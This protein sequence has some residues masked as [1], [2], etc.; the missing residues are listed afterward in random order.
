M[1]KEQR[2]FHR[3][4]PTKGKEYYAK[5][6][7]RYRRKQRVANN[8][9]RSAEGTFTVEQSIWQYN[10]QHRRCFW[11]SNPVLFADMHLDHIIPVTRFGTNWISNIVCSCAHCNLQKGTKLPFVEWVPP[12]CLGR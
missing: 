3:L 1:A 10:R 7:E 5:N 4:N 12:Q 11:C 9:L 2:E 6:P 8:R